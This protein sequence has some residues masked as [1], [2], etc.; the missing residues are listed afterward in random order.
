MTDEG[1]HG[2]QVVQHGSANVER[3][4]AMN[5]LCKGQ[6]MGVKKRRC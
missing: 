6:V 4:E 5:M 3:F 1:R 2:I